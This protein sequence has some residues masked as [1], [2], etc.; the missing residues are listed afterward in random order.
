[1]Q[2]NPCLPCLCRCLQRS[3]GCLAACGRAVNILSPAWQSDHNAVYVLKI[4][5]GTLLQTLEAA[6]HFSH[7]S[8]ALL[9]FKLTWLKQPS[10][11]LHMALDQV[12]DV[13]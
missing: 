12:G 3:A 1:M 11:E 5:D 6:A 10:M 7:P 13:F 4:V 9:L 2:C 8:A